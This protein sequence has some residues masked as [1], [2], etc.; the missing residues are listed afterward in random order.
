NSQPQFAPRI[1]THFFFT[2]WPDHDVPDYATGLLE[3]WKRVKK[4]Q[5]GDDRGPMIVHCS[6]GVGR[7]GAF[8]VI[9]A[10]MQQIESDGEIDVFIYVTKLRAQRNMMVQRP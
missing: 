1:V 3:L 8:I 4:K 2:S 10:M 6:A 5:L 7:T 9:D